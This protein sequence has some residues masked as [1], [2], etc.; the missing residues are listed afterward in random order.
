MK[1]DTSTLNIS[2]NNSSNSQTNGTNNKSNKDGENGA[3]FAGNMNLPEDRIATRRAQAQKKAL[4]VVGEAFDGDKAIDNSLDESRQRISDLR[5]HIMDLQSE[6]KNFSEQKAQIREDLGVSLDSDEQKE[7]ELLEKKAES[8]IPGS[9]VALSEEEYKKLAEID[10]KPKTEYQ[11]RA[12][13]LDKMVWDNEYNINQDKYA[14]QSEN[15]AISSIKIERLKTH[16]MADANKEAEGIMEDANK[17]I[18]GMLRDDVKDHIDEENEEQKEEAD[19]KAEE[20]DKKAEDLKKAKEQRE[21]NQPDAVKEDQTD[22]AEQSDDRGLENMTEGLTE[23]SQAKTDV[24][25]E[26]KNI[27]D[28]MKLLQED[29]KGITV[30]AQL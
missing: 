24:Q 22:S 5:Q 30:N 12:L 10:A 4:K 2:V 11:E 23:L 28:E 21:E 8:N 1:V 25:S 26:I 3:I 9:N 19:K 17:E 14:A 20:E 6:N 27:V 16:A 13:E 18:I 29:L 7:L 15:A